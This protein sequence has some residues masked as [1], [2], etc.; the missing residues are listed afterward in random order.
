MSEMERITPFRN[1]IVLLT[2]KTVT[3]IP[4]ESNFLPK[5]RVLLAEAKTD[6]WIEQ[7]RYSLECRNMELMLD[8]VLEAGRIFLTKVIEDCVITSISPCLSA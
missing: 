5:A 7:L 3:A 2:A 4:T 6:A 1:D 8:A